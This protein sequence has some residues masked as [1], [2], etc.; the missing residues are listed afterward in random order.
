MH[1]IRLITIGTK[2]PHTFSVRPNNSISFL[3][4]IISSVYLQRNITTFSRKNIQSFQL[5]FSQVY[6][7]V[8]F[9]LSTVFAI[10]GGSQSKLNIRNGR[11]VSHNVNDT[12]DSEI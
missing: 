12:M 8:I 4:Y 2:L 11:V 3:F 6:E 7:I 9:V 1:N 5:S 10:S